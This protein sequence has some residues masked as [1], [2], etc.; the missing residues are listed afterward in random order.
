MRRSE[1]VWGESP[2]HDMS[3]SQPTGPTETLVSGS[4]ADVSDLWRLPPNAV[5]ARRAGRPRTFA[6]RPPQ[7]AMAYVTAVR[8]SDRSTR[9]GGHGRSP[10]RPRRPAGR[11]W[12][13]AR[14]T[15]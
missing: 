11:W 7:V 15:A 6:S 14:R 9:G 1:A 4:V 13:A 10:S 2:A 3:D 8:D 12:R 5:V